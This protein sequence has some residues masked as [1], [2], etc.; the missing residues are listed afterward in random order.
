MEDLEDISYRFQICKMDRGPYIITY[1]SGPDENNYTLIQMQLPDFVAVV[2]TYLDLYQ[3]DAG[4]ANSKELL[5]TAGL[6]GTETEA[7]RD[8]TDLLVEK[9][10]LQTENRRLETEVRQNQDIPF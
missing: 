9:G 3:C 5:G 8:I 1:N 2:S 7:I 10:K 4:D 6:S